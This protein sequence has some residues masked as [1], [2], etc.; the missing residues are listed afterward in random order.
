LI[1]ST[2]RGVYGSTDYGSSWSVL[3]DALPGHLEAGP[4]VADPSD[5][6]TLY[7]GFALT[8]YDEQWRRV[9]GGGAGASR[10]APMDLAGAAAFLVLLGLAAAAAL[11]WLARR[12]AP[13]VAERVA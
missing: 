9:V 12:D 10:I 4:L 2:H 8:P 7:V 6:A 1:V 11:R 3:G 5:P 13:R